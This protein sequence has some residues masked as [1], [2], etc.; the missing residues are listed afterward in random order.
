MRYPNGSASQ[1]NVSSSFGPR[2]GGGGASTYHRGV[3]MTGIGQ[4]RAIAGGRVVVA[5]TP[6]GWSGGGTQVWIQHDGFYS[7]SMHMGSVAVRAGQWVDEGTILGSQD[8]TGTA[9]GSHL[10]LEIGYGEITFSNSGQIDPIPFLRERVTGGSPAGSASI[11]DQWGGR[12]WIVSIQEKLIRLGYNLAPW[13]A[14]GDPG[15][16]TQG[17]IRDFQGKNGLE[18]DGVAGPLTNAK[19]DERLSNGVGYN[20]IPDIRSTADVQRLV[21]AKVDGIWGDETTAKVKAWQAARPPLEADGIWGPQSDAVGFPPAAVQLLVDGIW[22]TATTEALQRSLS[23]PVTGIRDEATVKALQT[24]LGMTGDDVDGDFG[25]ITATL[26]QRSLGVYPDGDFGPASTTALQTLLN[27]GGKITPPSSG[28]P[29]GTPPAAT[30]WNVTSR[31]GAE[32]LGLVGAK[33][34]GSDA[35]ARI[36]A[37]Q[38][39]QNLDADGVWGPD[40]DAVGFAGLPLMRSFT[41][42]VRTV[43]GTRRKAGATLDKL[44]VHHTATPADQRGYFAG[45]NARLS[46]PTAYLKSDG[47]RIQ[48]IPPSLQ[49]WSTGSADENAIAVEIQNSTGA[50]EW[51]ISDQAG[52]SLV[53]I[54]TELAVAQR[55]GIKIDGLEVTFQLDREHIFLDRETRPTECPGPYVTAQ[56]DGYIERARAKVAAT[57][58]PGGPTP[59]PEPDPDT[60][61][62][63]RSWLQGLL[64]KLKAILGGGA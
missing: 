57:P 13:G 22:G 49:P 34:D 12:P 20:S 2:A 3:D 16:Q 46:M 35:S 26:L 47:R 64:E 55:D 31:A 56:I 4:I 15:P 25:P 63:S 62:V 5:G 6:S 23:V 38:T 24:A 45:R 41:S 1:P 21:G 17:A 33:A 9:T 27:R 59:Q 53:E 19:L 36:T 42:A 54:M 58:R 18:Q 61:P 39:A 37:W 50:P 7:R 29:T 10:H 40:S 8:T 44:G 30:N 43:G 11:Y 48:F 14:D 52:D 32:I 60:V 28:T 51:R